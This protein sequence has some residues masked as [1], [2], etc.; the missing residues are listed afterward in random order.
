[1]SDCVVHIKKAEFYSEAIVSYNNVLM[2]VFIK[3]VPVGVLL[4]LMC[5]DCN[6]YI[7][8][9]NNNDDNINTNN[10]NNTNNV[11]QFIET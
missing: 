11:I 7:N 9:D 5:P 8:S 4:T 3:L 2:K 1:M 10:N 6:K